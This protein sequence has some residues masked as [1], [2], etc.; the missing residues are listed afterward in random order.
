MFTLKFS[1]L[2]AK[3]GN[4]IFDDVISMR[5]MLLVFKNGCMNVLGH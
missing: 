1:L 2:F 3:Q 4:F 5:E